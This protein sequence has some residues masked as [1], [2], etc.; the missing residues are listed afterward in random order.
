MDGRAANLSATNDAVYHLYNCNDLVARSYFRRIPGHHGEQDYG[1]A[2][3]NYGND[4]NP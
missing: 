4:R 2:S 3:S 1:K